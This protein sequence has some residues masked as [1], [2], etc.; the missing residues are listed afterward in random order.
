M[1]ARRFAA[2]ER[3]HVFSLSNPRSFV[4]F[5]GLLKELE[6]P[7][8]GDSI[9][10]L[11]SEPQAGKTYFGKWLDKKFVTLEQTEYKYAFL[12]DSV[13]IK[14]IKPKLVKAARNR[15]HTPTVFILDEAHRLFRERE[16]C[17][18]LKNKFPRGRSKLVLLGTTSG[19]CTL[20]PKTPLVIPSYYMAPQFAE[21]DKKLEEFITLMLQL[22]LL[23][24]F[25]LQ[26]QFLYHDDRLMSKLTMSV[27]LLMTNH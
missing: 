7:L 20:S 18:F 19:S 9:I 11:R 8:S 25:F 17:G 2:H 5:D 21:D 27:Q 10:L 14:D 4:P 1:V 3:D 26:N 22:K 16:F 13:K 12:P 24:E 6:A 23:R 15:S